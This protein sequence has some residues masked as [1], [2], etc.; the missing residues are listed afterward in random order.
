M[1]RLV[2]LFVMFSSISCTSGTDEYVEIDVPIY[3]DIFTLDLTIEDGDTES[4]PI[5]VEP[6]GIAI[7]NEGYIYVSDEECV[8]VFNSQGQFI[9]Q[10]GREG[11]GPGEFVAA[12][13]VTTGPTGVLTAMDIL[14]EFNIYSPDGS[15]LRK[16]R[17]RV[18]DLTK[19]YIQEEGFTFTMLNDVISLDREEQIID[20]FALDLIN[21]EKYPAFEQLLFVKSDTLMELCQ[22][23]TRNSVKLSES[24]NSSINLSGDFLWSMTDAGQ[25]VYTETGI[26]YSHDGKGSRYFLNLVT[27]DDL[28]RD[29]IAVPY[30]TLRIP[31]ACKSRY[32]F[33]IVVMGEVINIDIDPEL[34]KMEQQTEFYPPLKFLLTDGNRLFGFHYSVLDSIWHDMDEEGKMIPCTADIID[35]DSGLLIA[36]AEFPFIP[37]VISDEHAYLLN[38]PDDDFPSI[39][40]YRI[41]PRIYNQH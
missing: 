18:E 24:S 28:E 27:L 30:T 38:A 1:K 34:L 25:I 6:S 35:L 40:R 7:N 23:H 5:L 37:D 17:Y 14:W 39:Q 11:Q 41:D 3:K 31:A 12:F 21:Q 4:E 22:Y 9:Q 15:F 29:T 16:S 33:S 2:L 36:R 19:N 20:L 8:K 26:D 10:I 13:G 32:E